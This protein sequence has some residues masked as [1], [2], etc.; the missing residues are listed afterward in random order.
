MTTYLEEHPP[1]VRQFRRPRRAVP[2]GLIVVHTAESI[3]D[4]IAPDTGAENVAAFIANRSDYG[5]YHT[6][7]DSDSRVRLVPYDAEAFGDATGSNLFAIH[8]SFACKATDWPVMEPRRRRAFLRQGAMAA[9]EAAAWLRATHGVEVPP[10]RIDR[11]ASDRRE[12]GF[13]SHA[14]RDPDRRTDPGKG[15]PWAA[16]LG[17]F[18]EAERALARR[19]VLRRMIRAAKAR[20]GKWRDEL[21]ALPK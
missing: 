2:S 1:K 17:E 9:A 5:S 13:I 6:V 11:P 19:P 20:I 10:A 4:R 3:L 14:Q 15:F 21:K 8:I 12:P 7:V 16:F 18:V